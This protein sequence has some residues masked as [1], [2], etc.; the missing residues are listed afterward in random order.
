MS[1]CRSGAVAAD[2][3]RFSAVSGDQSGNLIMHLVVSQRP[4]RDLERAPP[5]AI[6]AARM[7]LPNVCCAGW[8]AR[9]RGLTRMPTRLTSTGVTATT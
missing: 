1:L 3:A 4:G 7:P 5:S 2:V 9:R 6:E 8:G